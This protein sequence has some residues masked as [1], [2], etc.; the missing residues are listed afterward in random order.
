MV[1]P[2][3]FEGFAVQSAETWTQPK[4]TEYKPRPFEE[5]DI[6][7]KVIACGVCGSDV[8]T[9]TG[10]WGSCPYPLVV[11]HEIVGHVVRVGSKATT[12]LKVGDR[13]GVG[14]QAFACLQCSQCKNDNEIYCKHQLDT[15]GATFPGGFISQGGYASHVRVHEYFVF[16]IPDALETKLVA[17]M[18]CAGATAFSPLYRNGAAPGKKVG[19]VGIGG[20]GHF[21]IL[22]GKALGAE[23]WAISR[24][25][26]KKEDALKLGA[27]GYIATQEEN[28]TA[29][30]AMTFDLIVNCANSSKNFNLDDYLSLLDVNGKF[31]N[32]GLPEGDGF[33]IHP[34]KMM[35]NAAVFGFSHIAS[36]KEILYMLDLA[37]EKGLQPWVETVPV[38]EEGCG[39]ALKRCHDNDVKYRFT[40]VDYDKAFN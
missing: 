30:H 17:P 15:Y 13:V 21:G 11:G 7:I 34:F 10:G 27:D 2:D 4:R 39:T 24:S 19:I 25:N 26:A 22:F 18:L 38:G 3:T 37:A 29:P 33:Q 32:V 16:P 20:I 28:W 36:R 1:Y 31:I 14:A 23:V 5:T 35:G 9:V 12:G 6:D 8:H 40:L